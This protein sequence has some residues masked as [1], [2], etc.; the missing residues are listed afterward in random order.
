MASGYD[1]HQARQAAVAQLGRALARRAGSRC[2]LCETAG[3]PLAPAEVPPEPEAPD[4]QH[5]VMLCEPCRAWVGGRQ[6]EPHSMHFLEHVVWSERAPI[7][8]TAVRLLRWLVA[9][10]VHWARD[11]LDTLY[12][13]DEVAAWVERA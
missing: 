1:R 4:L 6:L 2:E 7:Q 3:V 12:L 8:V 5:A 10:E 11:L 9:D 13:S